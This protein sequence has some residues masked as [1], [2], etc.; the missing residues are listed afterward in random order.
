MK[1]LI[2]RWTLGETNARELSSQ[3]LDMLNLSIKFGCLRFKELFREVEFTICHNNLSESNLRNLKEITKRNQITLIDV[4]DELP[5]RLRNKNVK[6]SWWKYAPPRLDKKAYEVIMDND[7]IL[8]NIPQTLSRAIRQ[9]SLVALTDPAGKFYG[10]YRMEVENVDSE[11][12]LNAGLIGLPPE[13][14]INP[15]EACKIPLKD[16][17]HSE[18]GFTALKY[19]EY[20]GPKYLIGLDEVHQTNVNPIN[21]QEL[22][23]KY[24]GGHFCGCS[25]GHFDYWDRLYSS[26]LKNYYKKCMGGSNNEPNW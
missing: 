11:L 23:S 12:S 8:W 20:N 18:Q 3:A 26:D 5:E 22:L 13:F 16:F 19:A 24:D 1:K 2:I 7:L 10:D 21:S 4:S 25:Y 9:G 14:V 15:L 6:N 17:F